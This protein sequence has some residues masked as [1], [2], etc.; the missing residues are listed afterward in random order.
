MII[1]NPVNSNNSQNNRLDVERKVR[2]DSDP[3]IISQLM[4]PI[5]P[6]NDHLETASFNLFFLST[7]P[8]PFPY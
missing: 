7:S 2:N 1:G 3:T 5:T 4:N 6:K 8:L